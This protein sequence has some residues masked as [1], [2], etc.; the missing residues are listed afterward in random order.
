MPREHERTDTQ[1]T[2]G[3]DSLSECLFFWIDPQHFVDGSTSS[4]GYSVIR[5]NPGLFKFWSLSR[6]FQIVT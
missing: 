3:A 1:Q 2:R 5:E 6:S 4:P